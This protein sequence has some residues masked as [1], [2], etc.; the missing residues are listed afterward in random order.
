MPHCS[1]C[2]NEVDVNYK[3]CKKC[4]AKNQNFVDRTSSDVIIPAD[5]TMAWGSNIQSPPSNPPSSNPPSSNPPSSNPPSSNPPPS[6]PPSNFLVHKRSAAWYLLPIF[7]SLLG[8][9][10]AYFIIR[11][12]D[13]KKA[14]NCAILGIIIVL[15]PLIFFLILIP[16]RLF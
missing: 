6:N 12:D 16:A 3:F 7:F 2:Q 10:I 13:P 11:H 9:L 4:G 8:G 15:I 5:D 1:N 14:K